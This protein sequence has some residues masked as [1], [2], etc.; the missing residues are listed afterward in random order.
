MSGRNYSRDSHATRVRA[1]A[2]SG[3]APVPMPQGASPPFPQ[4][5][6]DESPITPDWQCQRS[7][8]VSGR[9]E[10]EMTMPQAGRYL[11]D[12][13][14]DVDPL[15]ATSPVMNRVSG[16]LYQVDRIAVPGRPPRVWR[17]YIE[18]WIVDLPQVDW[19][20]CEVT[21][22]GKSGSGRGARG[23]GCCDLD[24]LEQSSTCRSGARNIHRVRAAHSAAS[25]VAGSPTPFAMSTSRST[26]ALPSNTPSYFQ[27]TI[28]T[29]IRIGQRGCRDAPCRSILLYADAGVSITIDADHSVVDDSDAEFQNWSAAELHDAMETHFSHFSGSWPSWHLWGLMAG[30]YESPGVGGIMFDAAARLGGAGKAPERQ[31]F[32]VFRQHQW[33]DKLETGTLQERA[34]AMRH[35]LYTWVHEAGHAFNFLHSWD[36]S[37]PDSLS[38]MNY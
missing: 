13:R 1:D 5:R 3:F 6:S 17:T 27:P 35:F 15:H 20:R 8:A 25:A 18:S 37:R 26:S 30:I 33:F 14:I 2:E 32:A 31:G 21:I 29:H 7:G 4:A 11:L 34:W 22:A 28:R 10:G 16:D 24:R 19:D 23:D 36:K 9:Y 12:L 38:W